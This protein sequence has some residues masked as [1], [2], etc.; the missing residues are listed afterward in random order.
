MSG[1]GQ[2]VFHPGRAVL[3]HPEPLPSTATPA[4]I[5]AGAM[6]SEDPTSAAATSSCDGPTDGSSTKLGQVIVP[7]VPTVQ[8]R[9]HSSSVSLGFAH[10]NNRAS[11]RERETMGPALLP[12][13]V[14]LVGLRTTTSI[15]LP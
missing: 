4:F 13:I 5:P 10:A 1:V 15:C 3:P 14:T 7:V 9:V 8:V 2:H 11:H 12:M 6:I